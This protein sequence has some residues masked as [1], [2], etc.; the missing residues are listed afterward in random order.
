MGKKEDAQRYYLKH[1]EEIKAKFK[2][3][4]AE[5]PEIY[6]RQALA[7]YYAHREERLAYAVARKEV[8]NAARQIRRRNHE[9]RYGQNSKR[10]D[11]KGLNKLPYPENS[12]CQYCGRDTNL[13]YHHWSDSNPNIGVWVCPGCHRKIEKALPRIS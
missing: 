5:H 8:V 2:A 12:Q 1:K 13:Q 10:K 3:Y 4:A 7:Y 6:R 11:I 9:I